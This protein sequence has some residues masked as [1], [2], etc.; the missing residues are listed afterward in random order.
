MNTFVAIGMDD[1]DSILGSGDGSPVLVFKHSPHCWTSI[2]AAQEIG[3]FQVAHPN[4]PIRL[5]DVLANR[6]VSQ[7]VA[8]RLGLRHPSPQAILLAGGQ[9]QWAASHQ[10]IT[11]D[12]IARALV[13]LPAAT[14]S[15][16]TPA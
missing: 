2:F 9:V 4:I 13:R 5:I 7:T 16:A 12:G 8:E 1:L 3:R 6:A 10:D 15:S 11:E 14:G